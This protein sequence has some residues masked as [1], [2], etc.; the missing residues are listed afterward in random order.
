MT[1]KAQAEQRGINYGSLRRI[2]SD[3]GIKSDCTKRREIIMDLMFRGDARDIAE[4]LWLY[5]QMSVSAGAVARV[6]R[7]LKYRMRGYQFT[8]WPDTAFKVAAPPMRI[9]HRR[10]ERKACPWVQLE[11][12]NEYRIA[13]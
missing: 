8:L 7:R 9:V 12:F 3:L 11:L 1:L 5:H 13:A 6:I 4:Y 2:N 10:R